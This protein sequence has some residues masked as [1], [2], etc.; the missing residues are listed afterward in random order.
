MA[1]DE[2]ERKFLCQGTQPAMIFF[3]LFKVIK[4]K[5]NNVLLSLRT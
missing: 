4:L 3:D 2:G 5:I 1:I